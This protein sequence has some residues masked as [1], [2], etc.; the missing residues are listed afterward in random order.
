MYHIPKEYS[1]PKYPPYASGGGY[2][3]SSD[4]I[5]ELIP[6]FD[7]INPLKI[8]DAYVGILVERA[9]IQVF[10]GLHEWRYICSKDPN[11]VIPSMQM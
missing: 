10:G 6:H 5:T 9:G 3:L 1:K 8:D 7:L 11:G 2:V 4:A